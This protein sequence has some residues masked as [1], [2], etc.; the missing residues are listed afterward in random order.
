MK[1]KRAVSLIVA[2]VMVCSVMLVP[3]SAKETA[4]GSATAYAISDYVADY[5]RDTPVI[6]V[7]GMSQNDT[8]LLNEDGTRMTDKNGDYIIGW[9]LE[10]DVM[11]LLKE[12]LVPLL[13]SVVSRSDAGLT[14]A[15]KKGAYEALYAIHKDADGNYLTPVEVP[16]YEYP[17]S[18]MTEEIKEYYYNIL[19]LQGLAEIVGEENIYYFGYDS[20]GDVIGETEKLHHYIHDVVLP[21]TGADQV[22]LCNISLGG[23]IGV[24]YLETYPEDNFLIKRMLFVIPA[25]DGSDII[26]D[27]LTNNLSIIHDD[28]M[29]YSEFLPSLL[30]KTPLA[31]LLNIVLRILPKDVLKSALGGLAEGVVE[32]G[33][34][35]TT[36]I[37]ALC[38]TDY[39]E[40]AREKWLSDEEYA[41][42]REKVDYY[43]QARAN[44]GNNIY[45][46][47]E[48]GTEVFDIV[49]YGGG[50]FPLCKDYNVTNGDG[51]VHSTSASMG[52]TFADVGKTLPEDYVAAGTYCNNPA[53]DHISPDRTVD[54]TT[55]LLPCTT[56]Y[57]KNQDHEKLPNNDVALKMAFD[58]M[59]D[60]NID[61]VY[62]RPDV[63]P[64]YNE[65]RL[66]HMA[67][68]YLEIWENADKSQLSDSE[69]AYVQKAVDEVNKQLSETVVVTENWKEAEEELRIALISVNLLENTDPTS[70]EK[71]FTSVLQGV[72]EGFN[73]VFDYVF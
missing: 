72:N 12:A 73:F 10:I 24:N 5:D 66:V 18:E 51:I 8:Y 40:E 30:G 33:V 41:L 62:S 46:L 22:R 6:I 47:K 42:I 13:T 50:M 7:H 27:I 68:E 4:T 34:R 55:G 19:P 28:E 37:W 63:Y 61:D 36:I 39:Y 20:F 11:G 69:I 57:I 35:S 43:M 45:K 49:C 70:A 1:F 29:L 16:C 53:H 56:W 52:A 17:M 15:M 32:A 21:Q 26:G 9:P 2:L 31:Y 54:P 14:E 67:R 58:I 48:G 38:P 65:G 25:I 71:T 64:Q 59:T 44:F 23:T 3:V 60:E